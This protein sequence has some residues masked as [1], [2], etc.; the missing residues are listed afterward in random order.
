MTV[1]KCDPKH[2]DT[3]YYGGRNGLW[4]S[5]D[6]GQ[7]NQKIVDMT[8]IISDIAINPKE[9]NILYFKLGGVGKST[10]FG[11]TWEVIYTGPSYREIVMDPNH[12]DTLYLGEYRSTDG[13]E[14]WENICDKLIMAVHPQNPHI[15]YATNATYLGNTTVEVSYDWG[16]SFQILAEY[17]NGPLP[18]Y[19]I[20]CFR[21]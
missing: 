9:T 4:R 18:D 8:G 21:K 7:T 13:G 3:I 5:F 1:V 10:D 14:T 17:Q 11:D 12:P 2:P 6:G 20:Y 15:L 19:N 16:E